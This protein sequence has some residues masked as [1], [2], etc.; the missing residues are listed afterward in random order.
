MCGRAGARILDTVS[1]PEQTQGVEDT[2]KDFWATRPRRP[3]ANRKVAG[4][5]AAIGN[6]YGIDPVIV[7]VAFAV[8]TIYGGAGIAVYIL[9][10]LFFPEQD[11]EVSPFESM[12]SKG[13]SSTSTGFTVLL[14]LALIPL[15]GWLWDGPFPGIVGILIGAGCL[16]LLHRSRGAA[17]RHVVTEQAPARQPF[18]GPARPG[19]DILAE[20]DPLGAAPLS[21]DLPG[22]PETA[23]ET[24]PVREVPQ[25][26]SRVGLVT[27]GVALAV[28]AV[29][30]PLASQPGSW[31]SLQHLIGILLGV[32]GLGMVT[33]SFLRGG[34]GLIGLAV[35]LALAG[36]AL[37]SMNG[38]HGIGGID[39]TPTNVDGVQSVYQR[40]VGSVVLDFTALPASGTVDTDVRV[41]VGSAEI[42][43]PSD[44]DVELTCHSG[45]GSVQCLGQE[46]NGSR[47]DLRITDNGE[48]GEGGLHLKLDVNVGTGSV[49]VTRG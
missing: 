8:A 4:V 38:F 26:R 41:G 45:L 22:P 28:G 48:N 35:P 7:R 9:G 27:L 25:R 46:D 31:L 47:S 36:I 14:C 12:V 10:W 2:F 6:R 43:V 13:R 30:L 40:S 18:G 23:V 15:S 39:E 5:A 21:W 44:A 32:L 1:G 34:R 33:G 29:C 19:A 20:W 49:E 17:Y 16:Y 3:R 24:E 11:D 42:V 37:T